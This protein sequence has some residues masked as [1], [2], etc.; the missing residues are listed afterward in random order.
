MDM[1]KTFFLR[2]EDC[3][4]KW[5]VIDASDQILGRLATKTADLLRGKGK[6]E[7]S[8]HANCGDYV[9]IINCTKIHMTGNKW[10]DKEY[11]RYSGYRGG[12][13]TT[14][15]KEMLVK[16]PTDIIKLAVSRMLPKNRLSNQIIKRL[17]IYTGSDHPHTAQV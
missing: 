11:K 13:K 12:L 10:E 14:T 8:P 5:H 17:K 2:K 4:P 9:V 1:N 15:A 7:F 16:H 6:A 3:K